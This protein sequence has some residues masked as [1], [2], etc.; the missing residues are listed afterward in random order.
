MITVTRLNSQA[1]VINAEL[2]KFIEQ[3]P[4]TMITLTTGERIMVRETVNEVVA[5][6]IQYGRQVR[7]FWSVPVDYPPGP[8]E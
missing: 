1:L 4:D 3:T 8:P 5:R 6:A 2:I 7:A